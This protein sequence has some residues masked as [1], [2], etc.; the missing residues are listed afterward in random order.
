MRTHN[1]LTF[2]ALAMFGLTLTGCPDYSHQRPV[3]DYDSMTD[4]APEEGESG[5]EDSVRD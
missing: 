4:D 5:D 3:P 2:V 1:L